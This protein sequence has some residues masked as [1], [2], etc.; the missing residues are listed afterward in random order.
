[1]G[2]NARRDMVLALEEMGFEIETSH[3]EVAPAQ[4]EI[5]FRYGEG[6]AAA[7]NI[8]TFKLAVRTIA[9]RFG[10][11]ASF[12]PKPKHGVNGSGMHINMSVSKEGRNIFSEP[13]D[14][15]GLSQEAYY[16]MGG[17]M[18]HMRGMAAIT[19]PLVN[20]YKRLVPG[21]EAPMYI[22]WSAT[23]R[24][25]L[26]RIPAS[27]GASTRIELRCPDPAANPYLALAVCLAAGL[28]G[29]R[30]KIQ[31]PAPINSNI[32]EMRKSEKLALHIAALPADLYEAVKEMEKD[33]LVCQVLGSHISERYAKAKKAE[34][35]AYREQ[36]TEWEIS[37]YLYK[38]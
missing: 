29:I 1:M 12:M 11:F 9:K 26:I 7:D 4:H 2:E 34:W 24:S 32:F 14:E 36:V 17:L 22:A 18:E 35:R 5:D 16:F 3:H 10:L 6:L 19:N 30:R 13:S 15:W 33:A 38:I 31:P 28:D 37:N 21:Y 27:R 23:N 8:M 25:P 20:S